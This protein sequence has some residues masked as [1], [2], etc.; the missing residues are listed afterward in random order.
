MLDIRA[1]VANKK[2]VFTARDNGTS[3]IY[4][5]FASP[6]QQA[7]TLGYNA[8]TFPLKGPSGQQLT[9]ELQTSS[10]CTTGGAYSS[11]YYSFTIAT[12]VQQTVTIPLSKFAKSN[13]ASLK[14]IVFEP[15]GGGTDGTFV[16]FLETPI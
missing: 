16:S 7:S 1:D 2:L 5:N 10:A 4:T 8:L 15:V 13:L 11:E 6:C 14:S 12:S 3:Y 9:V